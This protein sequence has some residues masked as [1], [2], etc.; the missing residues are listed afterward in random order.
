MWFNA[1]TTG[2]SLDI[3]TCGFM[4]VCLFVFVV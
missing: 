4:F 3:L 1:E 2:L